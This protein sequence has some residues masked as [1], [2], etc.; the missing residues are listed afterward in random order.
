MHIS[1]NQIYFC[2]Y[3]LKCYADVDI[4]HICILCLTPKSMYVHYSI[5][6]QPLNLYTVPQTKKDKSN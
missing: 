1:F 4:I 5:Q 6:N 3:V 2:K